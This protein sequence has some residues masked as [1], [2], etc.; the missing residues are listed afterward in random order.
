M[1][2]NFVHQLRTL[3]E[4]FEGNFFCIPDYQRGYAWDEKQIDELFSAERKHRKVKYIM[5]KLKSATVGQI[6]QQYPYLNKKS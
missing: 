6:F 1:K 5:P 2:N 4:I 3:P